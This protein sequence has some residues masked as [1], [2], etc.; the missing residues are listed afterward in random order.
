M[1]CNTR[2]ILELECVSRKREWRKCMQTFVE[3]ARAEIEAEV[4][5]SP[6]DFAPLHKIVGA[7]LVRLDAEPCEFWPVVEL[8]F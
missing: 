3:C 2:A 7:K 6:Y 1:S 4:R 5:L 8:S